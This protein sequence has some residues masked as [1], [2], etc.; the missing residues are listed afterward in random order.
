M[1][2]QD[3]KIWARKQIIDI[4]KYSTVNRKNQT[5]EPIPAEALANILSRSHNF[6]K[7]V[8]KVI[9]SEVK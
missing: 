1:V 5:V 6:K 7:R 3:K 9:I 2:V 8:R 4:G